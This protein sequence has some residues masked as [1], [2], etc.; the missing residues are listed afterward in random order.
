MAT[1]PS[2]DTIMLFKLL[3]DPETWYGYYDIKTKIADKVAPGRAIR[4][5]KQ[6]LK[7]SRELRGTP[8]TEIERTPS[9]MIRLGQMACA[10]VALTSWKGKGIMIRGEGPYKEIRVKP[11]FQSWGIVTEAEADGEEQDP[12]KESEG[13]TEVPPS[14]SERSEGSQQG[15]ESVS[16]PV[17]EALPAEPEPV[18]VEP[19]PVAV[20]AEPEAVPAAPAEPTAPEPPLDEPVPEP[21]PEF[22]DEADLGP[23]LDAPS[24]MVSIYE[25]ETC[26]DCGMGMTDKAIHEDW[27]EQLRRVT[28]SSGSAFV[29]PETLRTLVEGVMRQA[30]T[31]F[32]VNMQDWLETQFAELERQI[33]LGGK[34]E[35]VRRSWAEEGPS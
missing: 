31:R 19:A 34:A 1:P 16:E 35:K 23:T 9:E 8:Q 29:D 5:Y 7:E 14:D 32:Q 6:R 18:A 27:H 4:K 30:L 12:G 33:R 11:G 17:A 28:A 10:Q 13:Y 25:V 26:P 21:T 15:P 24:Q 20:E 3:E 2:P 22:E